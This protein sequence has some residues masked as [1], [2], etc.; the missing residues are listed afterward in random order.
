MFDFTNKMKYIIKNP[1]PSYLRL[2]KGKST[3]LHKKIP[4][5]SIVD[6]IFYRF[7]DSYKYLNNSYNSLVKT[8]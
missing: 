1:Q 4:N 2:S 6:L 8:L 3:S 7:K 5:L